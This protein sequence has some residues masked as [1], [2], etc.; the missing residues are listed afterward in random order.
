VSF[1]AALRSGRVV[2]SA[3][4]RPKNTTVT[5]DAPALKRKMR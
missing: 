4:A 5:T 1:N 2:C 3:G